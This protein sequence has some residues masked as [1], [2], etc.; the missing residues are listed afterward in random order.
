MADTAALAQRLRQMIAGKKHPYS[1]SCNDVLMDSL[2]ALQ[3]YKKKSASKPLAKV[4]TEWCPG[5]RGVHTG[6]S[7]F[8]KAMLDSTT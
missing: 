4:E 8:R 6:R 5:K 2:E 7:H 1:G 3:S